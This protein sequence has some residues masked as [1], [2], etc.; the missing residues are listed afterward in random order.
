M[1]CVSPWYDLRP[2]RRLSVKGDRSWR[3]IVGP[4]ILHRKISYSRTAISAGSVEFT[5][6]F[7][8]HPRLKVKL[9]NAGWLEFFLKLKIRMTRH[10]HNADTDTKP[11]YMNGIPP[12]SCCLEMAPIYNHLKLRQSRRL[13]N[14][15]RCWWFCGFWLS[16][17]A[18]GT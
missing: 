12:F 1:T 18:N 6:L 13:I 3:S 11:W 5:A 2:R 14:S 7:V 15:G 4:Y 9:T 8:K 16:E 17:M 10:Q